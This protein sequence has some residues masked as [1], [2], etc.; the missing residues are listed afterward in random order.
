[1]TDPVL[2]T[3]AGGFLGAQVV[4]ALLAHGHQVV[5]LSRSATVP[6]RLRMD[7]QRLE[8]RQWNPRAPAVAG[9]FCAVVHAA[10]IYGR[11]GES[12]AQI[13][14][15]NVLTGLRLIESL[16]GRCGGVVYIGTG[17]P[18]TVSAYA[19]SKHQFAAWGAAIGKQTPF[20]HI[21]CEHLYGEKDDS[22]KFVTFVARRCL[23]QQPRLELTSGTQRRDFIHVSDAARAIQMIIDHGMP[24][25]GVA[26]FG[27]GS[28][29]AVTVRSVVERVHHLSGSRTEL[30]FGAIPL[31]PDEPVECVA[32]IQRLSSLNWQPQVPLDRGL[33][34]LVNTERACVS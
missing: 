18:P 20:V 12:L 14:E 17:L 8:I 13:V 29:V 2:I 28:G 25:C 32:D 34:D 15:A 22:T 26:E 6:E 4:R 3:G 19:C 10:A 30:V 33:T 16:Q 1:M 27:L 23:A 31:R 5:A 9:K 7:H 24:S 11:N 21:R